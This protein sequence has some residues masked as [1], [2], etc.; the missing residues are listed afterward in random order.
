M[1]R[2]LSILMNIP[3]YDYGKKELGNSFEYDTFYK[4]LLELGHSI[5]IFDFHT[6][7]KRGGSKLLTAQLVKKIKNKKYD[8]IFTVP[9]TDELDT[10]VLQKLKKEHSGAVS[11]AWM[12]D[13]KWRWEQFSSRFIGQFDYI[14]TTD[15][16]AIEKYVTA[17]EPNA[18][19]SQWA[20]NPS[21]YKQDHLEKKYEVSF[22][23]GYSPWRGYVAR[24]LQHAGIKLVCF[25]A[26]WKNG[27]VEVSKIVE[28][29]NQSKIVLNISNST[30][31]SLPYMFD[32]QPLRFDE[33]LKKTIAQTFPGLTD[34]LISKKR[35]EDIKARFFEVTGSGSFLLSYD[36]DHLDRYLKPGRDLVTYS[37]LTDLKIKIN[38]FLQQ[39]Q[40]REKIARSGYVHTHFNHTYE[41]RFMRIFSQI[42]L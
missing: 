21:V 42:G 35:A 34:F 1:A 2:K 5:D 7:F 20:H 28:I 26:G 37:S 16:D 6:E 23:G 9:F 27:R 33:S 15:P 30:Q 41:E 25:G 40:K 14:V 29:Y 4:Q 22:I 18:I 3:R 39:S 10:S 36:V 11:L 17:G 19:L 32:I 13:D 8:L 12:C 38:F 24:N 31:F